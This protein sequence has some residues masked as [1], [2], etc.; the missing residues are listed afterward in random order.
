MGRKKGK[1]RSRHVAIDS[2]GTL[3]AV[4]VCAANKADGAQAGVVMGRPRA[5]PQ[6]R[7]DPAQRA[8][9]EPER[10][11]ENAAPPRHSHHQPLHPRGSRTHLRHHERIRYRFAKTMLSS[12]SRAA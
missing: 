12:S 8:R 1:G 7:D 9:Q 10:S 2:Q 11:T 4:H 3:L 6:C 5:A